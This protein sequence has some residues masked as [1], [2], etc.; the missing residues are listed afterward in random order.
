MKDS[1][2]GAGKDKALNW[3]TLKVQGISLELV[4]LLGMPAPEI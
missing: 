2:F 4:H 3:V 1:G